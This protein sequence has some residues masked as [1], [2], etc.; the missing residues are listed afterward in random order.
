MNKLFYLQVCNLT[1][2]AVTIPKHSRLAEL[3]ER[4]T[5][6]VS[7]LDDIDADPPDTQVE[8]VNTCQVYQR[9]ETKDGVSG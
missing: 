6:I 4:S 8:S 5:V 1:N 9:Q 2:K 3:T 7:L